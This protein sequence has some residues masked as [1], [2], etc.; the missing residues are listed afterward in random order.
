MALTDGVPIKLLIP[1]LRA[2]NVITQYDQDMMQTKPLDMDKTSYLLDEKII[3]G[4]MSGVKT[5]FDNFLQIM[6]ECEDPIGYSL[7]HD[8]KVKCGIT[9]PTDLPISTGNV[10]VT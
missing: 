10:I 3:K 9:S 7:A 5:L 2:K 8:L 6:E 4:L 1:K